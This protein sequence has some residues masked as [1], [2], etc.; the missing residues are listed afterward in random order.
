M[1]ATADGTI[2]ESI[3]NGVAGVTISGSD[4]FVSGGCIGI[5]ASVISNCTSSNGSPWT[6]VMS[7]FVVTNVAISSTNMAL[8][9]AYLVARW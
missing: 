7:E 8:L 3:V 4:A 9:D 5:G 6:G 1:G 2:V